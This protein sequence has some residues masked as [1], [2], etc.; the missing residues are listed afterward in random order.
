MAKKQLLEVFEIV[1]LEEP[2]A[3]DRFD[4]AADLIL[5][6]DILCR[7]GQKLRLILEL[8][9]HSFDGKEQDHDQTDQS[10]DDDKDE[11]GGH[12]IRAK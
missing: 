5:F 4:D 7:C 6:E 3:S 9:L 1:L 8:S 11:V 2:E 12:G 10:A